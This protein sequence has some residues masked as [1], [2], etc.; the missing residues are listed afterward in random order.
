M[1]EGQIACQHCHQLNPAAN[2]FCTRCGQPL[3]VAAAAPV[4]RACGS[5]NKPG[6]RFCTRC[7]QPLG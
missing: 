1:T 5:Q 4:C 2:R 3:L 7:G 6:T